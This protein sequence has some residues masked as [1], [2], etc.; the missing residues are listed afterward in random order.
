M[1]VEVVEDTARRYAA[2]VGSAT[3]L[4][5]IQ[6][7]L[8]VIPEP[9]GPLRAGPRTLID[10][11]ATIEQLLPSHMERLKRNVPMT[12]NGGVGAA[13]GVASSSVRSAP[14]GSLL[15]RV[16]VLEE[17]V[18]VLLDAQEAALKTQQQALQLQQ[19][20]QMRAG[21]CCVVM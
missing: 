10:R 18:D 12:A 5:S 4:G 11:I 1:P 13:V 17:A 8:E 16:E 3:G 7:S 21:G 6:G 14:E 19:Q 20:Q 15:N 2:S 9:L